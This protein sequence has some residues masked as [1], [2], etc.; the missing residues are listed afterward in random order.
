VA[1]IS[2]FALTFAMAGVLVSP[3][4]GTQTPSDN[5][6]LPTLGSQQA[7]EGGL[8][9]DG[10]SSTRIFR[11]CNDGCP[12]LVEIPAGRFQM[13]SKRYSREQPQHSVGI[14]DAIA[15]GRFATTFDDW[16]ACVKGGGCV[17]NTAPA[18]EGWGRGRRPVINVTWEDA[19]EYAA[20]LSRKTGKKYRLLTEAEWEYAA[21]AGST[22]TYPWGDQI[23][24]GKAAYD[25]EKGSDCASYGGKPSVHGTQVVGT[26]QA[27]RWGLYDMI[28]N[29]WQ[30]CED[31]WHPDYRGAPDDGSA[32]RGGDVS[33]RIIRGGSWN[34]GPSALRSTDR[35]WF[36]LNGRTAFIGFRIARPADPKSPGKKVSD[37]GNGDQRTQMAEPLALRSTPG[38]L[39]LTPD[40]WLS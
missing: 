4:L 20:W 5:G 12:Q 27:N 38:G 13:G 3:C 10:E 21:R 9:R 2:I 40:K 17:R 11:D 24:C 33:M 18:D 1:N 34:Y 35:N 31:D 25:L 29:V 14:Y 37:A 15:V 7:V 19:E 6:N 8:D 39:K 30:W 23:D 36:P 28:G 26:Y 16:E 22:T 32:W